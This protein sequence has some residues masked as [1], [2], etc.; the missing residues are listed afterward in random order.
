[1]KLSLKRPHELFTFELAG[2]ALASL[3]GLACCLASDRAAF[4]VARLQLKD[5]VLAQLCRWWKC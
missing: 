3:L 5:Q 2:S 1:M 4:V